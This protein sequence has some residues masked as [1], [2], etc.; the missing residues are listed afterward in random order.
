MAESLGRCQYARAD[1]EVDGALAAGKPCCG[2]I[3]VAAPGWLGKLAVL[4]ALVVGGAPAG[5]GNPWK[6][7]RALSSTGFTDTSI[8]L[9]VSAT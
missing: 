8:S 7:G 2:W 5:A 9:S 3:G 1:G 4:P 6:N